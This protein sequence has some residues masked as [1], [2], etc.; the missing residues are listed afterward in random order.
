M[1]LVPPLVLPVAEAPQPARVGA[2]AIVDASSDEV[3]DR[4]VGAAVGEVVARTIFG[5]LRI[6]TAAKS[7]R[8]S[9]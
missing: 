9:Q 2:D 3:G 8:L 6:E 5:Q 4:V 7:D 1:M